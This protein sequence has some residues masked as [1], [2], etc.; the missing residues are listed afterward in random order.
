M[1]KN[2]REFLGGVWK[3]LKSYWCSEEKW[4][5]RGLLLVVVLLNLGIVYTLVKINDWYKVF[6]DLLQ[7][8]EQ[9]QF[10]TQIG[11]FLFWAFLYIIMA[12][13]ALYL[14]QV[15][16]LSWRNWLTKNYLTKWLGKQSY[17]KIQLLGSAEDNP[18][19]RISEDI[20]L[21][22]DLTLQLTLGFL[23]EAVTL[24]AFI[25]ILWNLSGLWHIS[26]GG[27]ELKIPGSMVWLSLAYALVG[28]ILT[29][30]IGKPLVRLNY[31]QQR[32][33]ADFRFSM[34]RLRENSESIAF[35]QGEGK[36]KQGLKQH[37]IKVYD[38][39]IELIKAE[40][41]L[42]WFVSG[43]GQLAVIFPLIMAAP[44]YFAKE[45]QLGG[46][47]QISSAFGR[48]QDSLSFIIDS[49]SGIA[50]WQS[51]CARLIDFVNHIEEVEKIK[52]EV[53]YGSSDNLLISNLNVK[54]PCGEQ[55]TDN[56]SLELKKGDYL[57]IT[58]RSG[59]GKS[60]LLRL[61]SGIW[62]FGS[63]EVKMP[64]NSLFLSQR[65]YLPQGSLR[66]ALLYPV[67]KEVS[68]AEIE[69]V[70]EKCR[71]EQFLPMLDKVDDWSHILSL[72]EQQRLA[73]A[74]ILIQKPELVFL[75]EATSAL[76]EPTEK[77]MYKLLNTELP[78]IS[79]ISVGH[80]GTLF[81]FHDL[82]LNLAGKGK[83]YLESIL[84]NDV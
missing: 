18:D 5:A 80:R 20:N 83:W 40:K 57:L 47:M 19:Q 6:Y 36:E 67:K 64:E 21:F 7:N 79:V 4:K 39:F 61:I 71:L 28:T 66:D 13:Y 30:K 63:G 42:T 10:W 15:L 3:L 12:V 44:R 29:V 51:V 8:Y 78:L 33:E 2:S 38:N 69:A 22:A 77:H 65:A 46:L 74:R 25:M 68:P 76:D 52:S 50:Q 32:K 31:Q 82:Q 84:N 45:I 53:R 24:G 9:S 35:Y 59:Q 1:Q 37:F 54:L 58:G 11:V 73:F 70:L 55:L 34:M 27:I 81:D 41:R 26:L 48:V 14:R 43:Y 60:T 49:Y 75:D 56:L 72:G 17:Y 16:Q 23:R 62:P